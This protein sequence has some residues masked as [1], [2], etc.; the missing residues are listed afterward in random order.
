[1]S[2]DPGTDTSRDVM[3]SRGIIVGL[4]VLL[5]LPMALPGGAADEPVT[6]GPQADGSVRLEFDSAVLGQRVTS[7]AWL[8]EA[9]PTAGPW[10][11]AYVLHDRVLAGSASSAMQSMGFAELA[12][13]S[14]LLVVAP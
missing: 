9:A 1:M 4:V 8:P 12:E 2:D 11:V 7:L 6:I 5:L 3:G 10:P 13:A 14:G